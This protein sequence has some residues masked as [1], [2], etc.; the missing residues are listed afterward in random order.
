VRSLWRRGLGVWSP[1]PLIFCIVLLSSVGIIGCASYT[2]ETRELRAFY[3]GG[4]YGE[5]L[6]ALESSSV[7]DEDRNRML[8]RMEKGSLLERMENRPAA[9]RLWIEADLIGDQ[10]YTVSL[11]RTAASFVVNDSMTDYE[12]EDY[13]K[14]GIHTQ[15]ALSYIADGDLAGARVSAKKINAKLDLLNRERKGDESH[16][17]SDAFASYLSGLI[18]EARGEWDDAIIDYGN[19]VKSYQTDFASYADGVPSSLVLAYDRLLARRGRTDRRNPLQKSFPKLLAKQR[20]LP[21]GSGELAVIHQVGSIAI[22][23]SESFVFPF[24]KHV[25]RFSFPVI[26]KTSR[27]IG[28]TGIEAPQMDQGGRIDLTRADLT[29]DMDLIARQCLEDR[30]F[31]MMTKSAARLIAKAQLTEKATENYG[32][33]GWIIGNVYSVATETADTRSWTLLPESY[34]VSRVALT[35]GKHRIKIVTDGRLS[36]FREVEIKPNQLTLLVDP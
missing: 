8:Y 10:L 3:R 13:E 2:D 30:R 19:A 17:R 11:S 20:P 33:L 15:L 21:S 6:K 4:S 5:A 26:R 22:K 14:V 9:R 23:Q 35:A 36:G 28:S 27:S 16:Y 31:R 1:Q 25:V 29:A 12:G 18:F 24:G 7:K 32:L 34:M